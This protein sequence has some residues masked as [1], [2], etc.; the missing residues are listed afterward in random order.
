MP[1]E[2]Q[3][4]GLGMPVSAPCRDS[5]T[6]AGSWGRCGD[7]T[8]MKLKR[9]PLSRCFIGS[10]GRSRPRVLNHGFEAATG[11]NIDRSPGR[12]GNQFQHFRQG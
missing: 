5:K 2:G 11:R 7:L 1:A 4:P 8:I 3:E 9:E 12:L 6:C 10:L